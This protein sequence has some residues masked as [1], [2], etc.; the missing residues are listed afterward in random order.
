V[1]TQVLLA[2]MYEAQQDWNTAMKH[3]ERALHLE[4][5]MALAANNLAY[6]YSEHGGDMDRALTLAQTANQLVPGNPNISDT[7]A[8]IYYKREHYGLAL[9]L[10]TDAA[11]KAPENAS[12]QL[13][14]GLTLYKTGDK[15]HS[16]EELERAVKGNLTAD[17]AK[18]AK[19]ALTEMRTN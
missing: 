18:L 4:P 7:L 9:P 8:W 12:V 10:L 5:S 1:Q 15:A 17:Q 13:H 11:K 6:L 3:Y 14:L 2:G 19:S 16:R